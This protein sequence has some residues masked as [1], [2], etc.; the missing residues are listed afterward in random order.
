MSPPQH[1]TDT[2]LGWIT[3]VAAFTIWGGV[4][5]FFLQLQAA[6]PWQIIAHRIIWTAA[7]L[8]AILGTSGRLGLVRDAGTPRRFWLFV[9][10]TALVTL[11]WSTYI[12]S[13]LHGF[14]MQASLGYFMTP[15]INVVLGVF[16][17]HER[18]RRIQLASVLLAG[19]GVAVSIVAAGVI[20][21]IALILG[22]SWALYG[23]VHKVGRMDPYGG[24]FIETLLLLPF[25]I[26]YVVLLGVTGQGAFGPEA[27]GGMGWG[28]TGLLVCAGF[29]TG[30]P[31]IL[32]GTG[33][34][35]L[36]LTSLGVAQ[37]ITPSLQFLV[38]VLLYGEPFTHVDAV[39]F[40]LI[41]S[42]LAI[43]T[44]D[45]VRTARGTVVLRT[46]ENA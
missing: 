5:I 30:I 22:I 19:A 14:I 17:L 26:G 15:L 20:P 32:F 9:L 11:N 24:L 43:Y 28:F 33:A 46:A 10:S 6:G 16:F 8:L 18:L 7:L 44:W 37:Y 21:W 4:P 35:H 1:T 39:T 34:R 27:T 31:L 3:A 36:P 13:A 45:T 12:W 2:R 42:G 38:S 23:L 41:W 29:V 25:C 40:G